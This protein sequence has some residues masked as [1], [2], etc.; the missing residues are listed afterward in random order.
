MLLRK[1]IQTVFSYRRFLEHSTI[2][3]I[4]E[5]KLCFPILKGALRCA[6]EEPAAMP[7]AA[8]HE[9]SFGGCWDEGKECL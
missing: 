9:V 5:K 7:A 4:S 8:F 2:D 3:C 1:Q 6:F